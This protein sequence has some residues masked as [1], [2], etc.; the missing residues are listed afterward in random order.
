MAVM[1]SRERIDTA[2]RLGKPDRIP[3]VPMMDVFAARYSGVT[4]HDL[5]FD[6][7]HADVAFRKVHEELGPIDGFSFSNA[8]LGSLV[9]ALAIVPPVLPGVDGVDPDA[10]FQFVEKTVMEADEYAA[11]A[12]GPD[13][14]M[15]D[16]AIKYRPDIN[17]LPQFYYNKARGQLDVFRV[18]LSARNWRRKGIEPLVGANIILF[19]LEQISTQ[20]RSYTD[21]V[22]DLYRHGEDVKRAASAMLKTW[23]PRCL[24]GPRVSG[25]RRT[26]IGLTRTSASLLSPR[27]FEEFAL[28]DLLYLCNYLI[29]HDITPL[30]HFDNDWTPFFHYFKELPRGKCICNLDGSSDIFKA[31]EIL[32]D[33]MCIMGDVPAT[34]LKLAEPQDVEAYCEKLIREI[35]ADGGFI[36]SSGCD[37]PIDAKPENVKV[38][39]QSVQKFKP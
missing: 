30:L 37:V 15:R 14:F 25:V 36:L 3:V 22:A 26:F 34:L 4:Q 9:K 8:G 17:G 23:I 19:P 7:R 16:K 11:L 33:H 1:S 24:M 27:Q 13:N 10:L 35:G 6:I 2:I 39:F 21:F 28:Q 38:M 12:A 20:L 32:G 5:I 31:K 18:M 29:D